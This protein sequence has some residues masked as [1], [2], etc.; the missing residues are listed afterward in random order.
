VT[1]CRTECR[2]RPLT[3][4][5]RTLRRMRDTEEVIKAIEGHLKQLA[6]EI[7]ALQTARSALSAGTARPAP[8]RKPAARRRR[9][10]PTQAAPN[11]DV[12]S[13]APQAA[14]PTAAAVATP[15]RA[16]RVRKPR[17]RVAPD[18]FEQLLAGGDG[19]TTADV[20]QQAGASR[21]QV[22]TLLRDLEAAGRIRRTGQRRSTRWHLITDEDRI[23]QRAAE[24]TAQSNTLARK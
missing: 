19:L 2:E 6:D 8:L 12:P 20:A 24:L 11:G 14:V 3:V 5:I 15:P 4:L 21:D 17:P 13:E 22:L 23:A 18:Q 10:R 9:A 7:T 16:R 1:D